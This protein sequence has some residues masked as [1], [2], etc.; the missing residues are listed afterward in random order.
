MLELSLQG[1]PLGALADDLRTQPDR[2]GHQVSGL[3]QG[4]QHL[5]RALARGQPH[6]PHDQ[7]VVGIPGQPVDL[8][9]LDLDAVR[10]NFDVDGRTDDPADR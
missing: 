10:E 4:A 3:S 8:P 7:H 6:D 5:H 9:V 2:G 1:T